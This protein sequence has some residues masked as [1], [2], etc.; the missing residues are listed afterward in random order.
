[1]IVV[2]I[3]IIAAVDVVSDA[4]PPAFAVVRV[5][6]GEEIVVA[7]QIR[8]KVI[9][10]PTGNH[11]Q[12]CSIRTTADRS[13]TFDLNLLAI[14]RTSRSG[15]TFVAHADI[16]PAVHAEL[17]ATDDVVVERFGA[18]PEILEQVLALIGFT[19]AIRIAKDAQIRH[20]HDIKGTVSPGHSEDS[21]E[22]VSEN[23]GLIAR[24]LAVLAR[25]ESHNP[26]V[27]GFIRANLIHRIFCHKQSSVR[28][29][30]HLAGESRGWNG[31]KQA[32]FKAFSHFRQV[33]PCV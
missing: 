17:E 18:W 23:R 33:C 29:R 11:F 8:L 2:G 30:G 19:V 22:I 6:V 26:A 3:S 14:L 32:D 25:C 1:M 9:A 31:C 27:I 16:K 28:C 24:W 13:A 21:T 15:D 10:R 7:V 4:R 5:V 20:V 12:T